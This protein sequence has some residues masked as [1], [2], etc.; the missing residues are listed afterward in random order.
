[1]GRFFTL[2]ALL[3]CMLLGTQMAGQTIW[4]GDINNN[5]QV[6]G[7][8]VLYWGMANGRTGAPR[9]SSSANWQPQPMPSV[10]AM[11][12]PD[13]INYAYADANGDG[14][15]NN[16]DLASALDAH[17]GKT[18]GILQPDTYSPTQ[19]NTTPLQI[20]ALSQTVD[21]G[22]RV[23]INVALGSTRFRINR[24]YGVTFTIS[25]DPTMV[26]NGAV[27]FEKTTNFWPD[28][29]GNN[30]QI[31]IKRD[32]ANGKLTFV[33]TR[34]NQVTTSGEGLL[35]KFGLVLL[36]PTSSNKSLKL[37]LEQV[38]IID[39]TMETLPLS[40]VETE[41]IVKPGTVSGGGGGNGGGGTVG[42]CPDV[43]AP[44]CGKNGKVYKNSC[45]AEA[46]GVTTYTEGTCFSGCVN[47]AQ[48]NPNATCAA[49]YEPV[50]GCNG[51]TYPNACEATKAGVVSFTAGPCGNN[52]N[53][54]DPNY[55]V[56]NGFAVLNPITRVITTTCPQVS[57]P[58]CGCNG[59]TYTNACTAEANGIRSYTRGSCASSCINPAQIKPNANIPNV[60]QPVC[61]CNGQT[62]TNAAA[63]AAAGVTSTTPGPCGTAS[64]WCNKAVP[65]DCGNFLPHESTTD[66]G[67]NI[68]NYPCSNKSYPGP[69]RVYV[70]NKTTAGDLQVGLEIITP[71][72]DLDIF[73]LAANC[74][75]LTCLKSSTTNNSQTNNEGLVLE[76]API[77]TYYLI[78]DG[79]SAGQYRLEVNCGYL[80]CRDAVQ[81]TCGQTYYG[82]N[83][84]GHDNV[85][86]YGCGNI[87]NVEN[88]GPEVVHTFTITQAGQVTIN[89]TGLSANLELFLLRS[90]NRGDCINFSES[91]GNSNEQISVFL[92]PGTYY[93]V[94]DG[95]NGA[96]SNY[97]LTVNCTSSCNINSTL[98]ATAASC[99]LNNGSIKVT[100]S[101]GS[102]GYLVSYTGP[103]SGTFVTNANMFHIANLPA[104]VYT[105][106]VTDCKNCKVTKTITV[107]SQG[108]LSA[109]ATASN[110]SCSQ[111]GSI[112]VN[113]QNGTPSYK[114]YVSGPVN[115]VY[116]TSN[117]NY[118]IPNLPPGTYHLYIVDA[119][120]CTVSRSVT[121]NQGAGNFYFTATPNA[122]ACETPGSI[123]IKTF[124]GKAPYKIKIMGPK[125]GTATSNA[126]NFNIVQLPPG[127]YTITIE[128]ANW[129]TFTVVVTV[130]S[131]GLEA[132]IT[133]NASS[134]GASGSVQVHVT[135]G[136]PGFMI[137]WTGPVTGN[138][139]SNNFNTTIQNLP[140]G[141]YTFTV[142]DANWCVLTKTVHVPSGTGGFN[143][144]LVP[145]NANCESPGKI[146]VDIIGGTKPYTI[147]W[148][149]PQSGSA[150][151]NNNWF[152]I[153]NLPAGTYTVTVKDKNNCTVSKTTHIITSEGNL[154]AA[155]TATGGDC[156]NPNGS[157]KVTISGGTAPFKVSWSGPTSGNANTN[158]NVFNINNLPP[159]SYTV[160][161]TDANWCMVTKTIHVP[162]GTG[163]FEVVLVPYTGNC[164]SPGRI[165]VEINGGTKP[166][167]ITWSGTQS[168]SATT[169]NNVFDINNLPAGNYTV[170]VK[171][172]NNCTVTRSTHVISTEGNLHATLT[173]TGGACGSSTGSIAVSIS[174][175]RAPFKISWTGPVSGN[176][177][178]N[179][180]TFN[181][182]NLPPGNYTV[183]VTDADWCMVTKTIHVPAGTGGFNIVLV[184]TNGNC[185][186]PGKIGVDIIGGTKPYTITW[187][188]PQSGSAS[189]NGNWFDIVN[190]VAGTYTVTVK[191][192]NNCTVSNTTH[193]IS[194]QGNLHATLTATG[195]TC[196][197][198]NGSVTVNISGGRAPFK[199]SWTGPVSGNANTNSNVFNINNLPPGNYTVTV[200]DADWCMVT[201]TIHVPAG[202]GGFHVT[203]QPHNGVCEAN[204]VIGVDIQGGT[205]PYLITWSGPVSGSFST[206]SNWYG[207]Q[208]LPAGTYT[209]TVKDKNNC[210]VTKTTTI[211][212]GESNLFATLS[213]VDG[214]CVSSKVRV[215]ITGGKAPYKIMWSGPQNGN[216]T[217][218]STT[219]DISNLPPGTYTIS[220]TDDN[221]CM[222]SKTITISPAPG[223]LF[224]ATPTNGICETPGSIKLNFIGGMPIY[225]ISWTGASS[226][227]A[228][229]AG[230]MF[231]IEN[232]P[233]GNYTIN[234]TD[235]KGCTD[236]KTVTINIA[237]GGLTFEWALI[238]N[239]CGQFNTIWIDIFGGTKPYVVVWEGPINGMDTTRTNGYEIENLP[240]GKYTVTV[241]DSNW[242][243]MMEMITIFE[244]P[245]NIF[246]ATANAGS[247]S[248]NGS[249]TLNLT[250][251]PNYQ[252]TWSGPQNGSAS[253]GGNNY[254]IQNVPP[255]NYTI[256]VSDAKGCVDT[257]NITLG[258]GSGNLTAA[259][260]GQN[261]NCTEAGRINVNVTNGAAPFTIIL[262]GA[263][264]DTLNLN[265][266]GSVQFTGLGAGNYTVTVRDAN[267]CTITQSLTIVITE[268]A[269]GITTSQ[270]SGTCSTTGAILVN[271]SGGSPNYTISWTGGGVMGS[272]MTSGNAFTINNLPAGS[273]NITVKDLNNCSA[274][275]TVSVHASESNLDVTTNATN[276]SCGQSGQIL[277]SA[278][279]GNAPFNITWTGPMNGSASTNN[280]TYTIS[281][282]P[283][284]TYT[285]VVT[286]TGGC[287]QTRTMSVTNSNQQPVSNFGNNIVGSTVTFINQSSPGTYLWTFGDGGTS[288]ANNPTHV[289]SVSNNYEVCL[290]VSNACGS[291]T[292]C[293]TI[294][295]GAPANSV[296]IDV[297]DGM[298]ATGSTIYVPVTI[299]N[300][301]ASTIV[302]FAGSL[303]MQDT[304]I[305]KIIGI[306]AGSISPQYFA[307]NRTFSYFSNTGL[308]VTCGE[309]QIL[310]YVEVELKGAPGTST[311]L[312]ILGTPLAVELGGM[313]NGS[314]AAV[315][316]TLRNGQVLVANTAQLAGEIT[317]YWGD[318]LPDVEVMVS[319]GAFSEMKMT[320]EIGHYMLP[321]VPRG[322]MYTVQP[323]RND[324]PYNGLSTYALFAGQRF[325][326]G[327]EPE[328][329]VSPYQIIAGDANCDGRFTTLDLFLIQRLIIGTSTDFGDC[330][331]WVF[332]KAGDQMPIEFNALNVFP[333]QN[334]DDVMLMKDTVSNFIGVKVGDI[335]GHANPN[336]LNNTEIRNRNTLYLTAENRS[337]RAGEVLE[338]PIRSDNFNQIASYQIGWSFDPAKLRFL[339]LTDNP[340][341]GRIALGAQD[342]E[343][344]TLRMSWFD[345]TGDGTN[346]LPNETLFTLRFEVLQDVNDLSKVMQVNSRFIRAEAHTTMAE[347]M[348][349][350]LEFPGVLSSSN[351]ELLYRY[352][353]HQNIPNPFQE[354]TIIG[355]DLPKDMQADLII[356]DQ[357]GKIVQQYSGNYTRGYNQVEVPRQSLS[358]GVYY[359]T[360]RTADFAATKSMIVFE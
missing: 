348:D 107:G 228:T 74:G 110:A 350:A 138:T 113:I 197:S 35:G 118:T 266:V 233:A 140:G 274:T 240:P 41:V 252:I 183:T 325:I 170:T 186:S 145:T 84:N 279:G 342:A 53:C 214:S 333:Y 76:N 94:V 185:E 337:V 261:G 187:S 254:A 47:P 229:A 44:V 167:T 133:A 326:L 71:G 14:V 287:S 300:C 157:I 144:V 23:D 16:M 92:Q 8:D 102:P 49:V 290:T 99:G 156:T 249:I 345:L 269:V 27:V 82:S 1:M 276:G 327:M 3:I 126:H 15:I 32:H 73:L 284:G 34:T 200:T 208:N 11:N 224:T 262:G 241:K 247:C 91:S 172:K 78:V 340:A 268:D 105:I 56:T 259:I 253:V 108:N 244:T 21:A 257:K 158:S 292:T 153:V 329:I 201:K 231:T 334:K 2:H 282:L 289:Y 136:T 352:K 294:T 324:L 343:Q 116:M 164:E 65:L 93:V 211:V 173:T 347:G 150:T 293:R 95:Y 176:A 190:L 226:G 277:V 88:N 46:A 149:G 205:K 199:I 188:G 335:L 243:F 307:N 161:V 301:V 85:S 13:G 132:N 271:I 351:E 245:A 310:F 52:S 299:E 143:V 106:T 19:T 230:N 154:H 152:D 64:A 38:K 291:K 175:G 239:D 20:T 358:G 142:K 218:N 286:E 62:Y 66:A 39:N 80:D 338:I 206:N 264:S 122:A 112:H 191:D 321:T 174:G 26:S 275:G 115:Q 248:Q 344:G 315:P 33:I 181:I 355:F 203:L 135:S 163:G 255:G 341:F 166:Y 189:T 17:F 296:V 37:K 256:M 213:L 6:N 332:V 360:L 304:S 331:S 298:G 137:S 128:D 283:S 121:I 100:V 265:N 169:N 117:S 215:S 288:S 9:S 139:T 77:G 83:L 196:T 225:N 308:G 295:V 263:A 109:T 29:Q 232:L 320:D 234:V 79:P 25:Y 182:N 119:N 57:D 193:I 349:I 359:Y 221:W 318:G 179:A 58:V 159:G 235:S 141:T 316:Y 168:G 180:F 238:V 36:N 63:A 220:I 68:N 323:S 272:A 330:P 270:T 209:V 18:H 134:C 40:L 314:P 302:S 86:L 297:Q 10:W 178:T 227:S 125:S 155:L 212:I 305:A 356:F 81:L 223:N 336:M 219:F 148:S 98:E 130:P 127:T 146:G 192:K 165:R 87:Y 89:L 75:Q 28:P 131:S 246:T 339:N 111:T 273:Y 124:N 354:R 267:G 147:T 346:T 319:N 43:I 285:I 114:I 70:I 210:T 250:G 198:S 48:M 202:T 260:T 22:T 184:P 50:C 104:G 303:Q 67:N 309:G 30:S 7:I 222:V 281:N 151:T 69:E 280:P 317:T 12:F 45:Y 96:T 306:L 217:T 278:T 61:G 237:E 55:V 51:I 72:L 216:A 204:G 123:S 5:G 236:S 160:T 357:L 97:A 101:N 313:I 171:D 194:T 312:N 322:S 328:E 54:Y 90:C 24:F 242:C 258:A 177:N 103:K 120:G 207:I 31:F 4:P 353:L 162:G 59:I 60:Y 195:G 42:P 251:T 129:C 311:L